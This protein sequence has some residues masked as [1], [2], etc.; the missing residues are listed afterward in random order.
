MFMNIIQEIPKSDLDNFRLKVKSWLELD[1][2]I[3]NLE[4]KIRELKKVRNKQLEPEIT[5][6]MT[7]FNISDLNTDNGKL[8]CNQRNTK[9]PL[10]KNNIRQNLS[11]VINDITKVDEA[12][13]L[14]L[15]NREI[16]TTYK[17]VK[18]KK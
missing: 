10:N 4:R 9:K 5:K 14:I 17:L 3:S 13:H 1:T 15:N 6:F 18:T 7:E 16:T 12:M 2:E 11:Q 8:K